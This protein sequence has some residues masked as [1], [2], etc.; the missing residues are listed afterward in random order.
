MEE[1]LGGKKRRSGGR[2][3][4]NG[5]GRMN[6][7]GRGYGNR[8]NGSGRGDRG[9]GA[10]GGCEDVS[11]CINLRLN[12]TA[13]NGQGQDRDRDRGL[14]TVSPAYAN[15]V[16]E[17]NLRVAHKNQAWLHK[18]ASA[19]DVKVLDRCTK[20]SFFCL[21]RNA[22]RAV[23]DVLLA[24]KSLLASM[25]D[26]ESQLREFSAVLHI[27]ATSF[28]DGQSKVIDPATDL[29]A[30]S[31][32]LMDGH[33]TFGGVNLKTVISIQNKLFVD[34]IFQKF[35]VE[36]DPTFLTLDYGSEKH[37]FAIMYTTNDGL[38]EIV[39]SL[40]VD[41]RAMAPHVAQGQGTD[42]HEIRLLNEDQAAEFMRQAGSVTRPSE[43]DVPLRVNS[44]MHSRMAAAAAGGGAR[45][46][47]S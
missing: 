43:R 3:N 35:K 9:K 4:G 27:D 6:G 21:P 8:N 18:A 15:E 39:F 38:F 34:L 33:L 7:R 11:P 14:D 30:A 20:D 42:V 5:N 12:G 28:R 10:R 25:N 24:H 26:T 16:M 41:G 44:Y 1:Q 45:G 17:E 36:A 47:R 22:L 19:I 32:L 13:R 37:T 46:A 40:G 2:G 23:N 29:E 31:K